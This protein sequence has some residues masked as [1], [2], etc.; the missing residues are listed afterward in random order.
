MRM[1]TLVIVVAWIAVSAGVWVLA[2]G[3]ATGTIDAVRP[4]STIDPYQLH[5]AADPTALPVETIRDFN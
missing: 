5:L 3:G 4:S 1:R 2:G